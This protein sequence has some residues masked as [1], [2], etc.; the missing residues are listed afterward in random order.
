MRLLLVRHGATANNSEARFT[1]QLDAPLSALGEQQVQALGRRLAATPLA[2]VVCSDLLRARATAGAIAT[3]HQPEPL[4][5]AEDPDLREIAM[6]VW[7]G[8]RFSD[9]AARDTD[10]VEAWRSDPE[11]VAPSG[12]PSSCVSGVTTSSTSPRQPC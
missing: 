8:Q 12:T 11:Q 2:A 10:L 6:G 9:V 3:L 4:P 7:E 5:V 1:G